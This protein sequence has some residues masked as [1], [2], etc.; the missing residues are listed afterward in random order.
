M[1][2]V[3]YVHSIVRRGVSR[4]TRCSNW[5]NY[6]FLIELKDESGDAP[7][8]INELQTVLK[9]VTLLYKQLKRKQQLWL[10]VPSERRVLT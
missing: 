3:H 2:T 4:S 10:M 1:C 7:L 9:V 6:R 8:N 5:R